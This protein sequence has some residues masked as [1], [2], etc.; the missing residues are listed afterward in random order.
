MNKFGE[1]ERTDAMHSK[2]L[3]VRRSRTLGAD[4]SFARELCLWKLPLKVVPV[5]ARLQVGRL[6]A[7]MSLC[8]SARAGGSTSNGQPASATHTFALHVLAR[9]G[10]QRRSQCSQVIHNWLLRPSDR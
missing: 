10:Q 5:Y 6:A 9:V 1:I 8:V 3:A 4:Q 2:L 7:A